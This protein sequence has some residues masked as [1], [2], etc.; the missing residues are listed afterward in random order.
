MEISSGKKIRLDDRYLSSE[1]LVKRIVE[2]SAAEEALKIM[3]DYEKYPGLAYSG[4]R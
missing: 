2:R 1:I 3:E 4:G